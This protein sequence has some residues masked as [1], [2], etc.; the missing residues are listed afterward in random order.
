MHKIQDVCTLQI[1]AGEVNV[2]HLMA[3]GVTLASV[4]IVFLL[5]STNI[6]RTKCGNLLPV[7]IRIKLLNLGEPRLHTSEVYSPLFYII[8]FHQVAKTDKKPTTH[9][10]SPG[11]KKEKLFFF[12][13][14]NIFT[15]GTEIPHSRQ[16]L[17][18]SIFSEEVSWCTLLSVRLSAPIRQWFDSSDL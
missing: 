8:C 10:P 12:F 2:C 1:K 7:N 14:K 16:V 9:T 15:E 3:L 13:V 4:K 11:Q 6:P 18:N 17:L 5:F